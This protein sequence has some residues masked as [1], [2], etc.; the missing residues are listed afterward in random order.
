[1]VGYTIIF[2]FY[3]CASGWRGGGSFFLVERTINVYQIVLDGEIEVYSF[4]EGRRGIDKF[5]TTPFE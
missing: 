5:R 1:M 4:L 3:D 2:I